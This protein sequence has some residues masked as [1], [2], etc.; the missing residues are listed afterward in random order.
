MT[1]PDPA[2]ARVRTAVRDDLADLAPEDLVLVACSGGADSLALAA[3]TAFVAP[4]LGLRAGAVVVDHGLAPTSAAVTD[5]TAGQCRA[6]G[7]DPVLTIRVTVAAGGLEGRAREARHAAFDDAVACTGAVAVLLAHT[8]DDQAE[9]VLLRLA[10]GSGARSLAGIAPR[11][12]VLR[13]PLLAVRRETLRQAC[14]AQDLTW[15]EDPGNA[16]DGPA[17]TRDGDALPRSAVR[18]RVLPALAAAVGADPVTAL[19]RTAELL[20]RDADL[21]DELAAEVGARAA[22]SGALRVEVLAT[23]HAA[24][25]P[26]VLRAW[27]IAAG[28]PAGDVGSQ[29]LESVAALVTGWRGQ[30]GVDVP[31]GLR[32]VR[33]D[34]V[35]AVAPLTR[36]PRSR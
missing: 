23:A 34:G 6:L 21:L 8:S 18:H 33:R 10:R 27:L 35:L 26:R 24:L 36:S 17:T 30:I 32:V 12:G 20:R 29:H 13:R 15:W 16:V 25:L 2:V 7:L 19:T 22:A 1:G 9:T 31:G 4:R 11:R 14:R 28:A 3:A 5:S